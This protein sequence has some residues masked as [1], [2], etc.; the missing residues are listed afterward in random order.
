MRRAARIRIGCSGWQYRHWRGS[1][2]PPELSQT[3]WFAH[4]ALHF[5]TVEINNTFYRMPAE[6]M[7]ARW[8]G[9][10]EGARGSLQQALD[11]LAKTPADHVRL[12]GG[13]FS[14]EALEALCR[15]DLD[16]LGGGR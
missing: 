14:R 11:R 6:A 3:R 2:Y 4:Y 13:G 5:D 12:F 8:A 10:R 9:D 1:F 15:A 16:A 7:L